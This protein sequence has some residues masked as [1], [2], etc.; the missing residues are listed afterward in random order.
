MLYYKYAEKYLFLTFKPLFPKHFLLIQGLLQFTHQ[1]L[2]A[3]ILFSDS[4]W[5]PNNPE[6]RGHA[7]FAA[8]CVK[9][10]NCPDEVFRI[11][12]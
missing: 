12:F 7:V 9:V 2:A 8:D 3:L 1:L 6:P 11:Y 5:L 4:R 10:G